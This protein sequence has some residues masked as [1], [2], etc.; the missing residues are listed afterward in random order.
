MQEWEREE[1]WEWRW[2]T[3]SISCGR[4]ETNPY[5]DW[6]FGFH[7]NEFSIAILFLIS[8]STMIMMGN[9]MEFPMVI[10]YSNIPN[11]LFSKGIAFLPIKKMK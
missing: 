11:I 10:P 2:I 5:I 7:K 9:G 3:I 8:H 6:G 1:E 4:E